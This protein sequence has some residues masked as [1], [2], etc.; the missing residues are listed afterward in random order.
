MRKISP[1]NPYLCVGFTLLLLATVAPAQS[2][3]TVSPSSNNVNTPR[4]F[5]PGQ[6]S[7]NPSAFAVQAQNPFLGSVPTGSVVPGILP[8]SLRNAVSIA[9]RANLGF[10]DAEQE[11]MQT[12]AARMRALAA[13]LPQIRVESTEEYRNLVS[14][15]LGV[16]K[17]GLPHTIPAFTFQTA[18][19]EYQQHLLDLPAIFDARA[20]AKEVVA[21][22]AATA[23]ARNIVV[24]ASVSSYLLVAA[25]Q[26]RLETARAQLKTATTAYSLLATRLKNDLSPEIDEIRAHVAMK[27]AELRVKIATTTLEKDKLALTRIIGLPVEQEFVLTDS[28]EYTAAPPAVLTELLEKAAEEREDIKAARARFGAAEQSVRAQQ[29][30]RLPTIA[31]RANAGETGITY[32][33]PYRD[34][35]VEGK[36]SV[37]IFTGRKIE[38]DVMSAKAVLARRRAELADTQ[39][40]AVYDVRAAYLDLSAAETSVE[41]SQ[42]NQELAR[43]GLKQARDRFDVGVSN[44]VELLQA[45]QAVAEA[46]DN[47]I[48]SVY[49]HQLAKLLLIRATGT[50]EAD[51]ISFLGAR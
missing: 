17:L 2:T 12:R 29:A 45:Q 47:R 3:G 40:R 34:Y 26:T 19:V 31:V 48:A 33:H 25:S 18:H 43:R 35:D 28:L 24:L 14:D 16:P 9:L 49:A 23:D 20:A 44:V 51:Y 41:V 7:T 21:S 15:V 36:I 22:S 32:G 4:P 10:V 27:S 38:S 30:Q 11:H 8:L 5:D 42:E 1:Q 39:A 6:N 46:E 13:L 50:A 37:P